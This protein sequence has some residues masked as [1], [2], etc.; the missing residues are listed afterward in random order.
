VERD[1]VVLDGMGHLVQG[2][3]NGTG[4]DLYDRVNVTVK[5]ARISGFYYGVHI[6]SVDLSTLFS[7]NITNNEYGI[8]YERS[9]YNIVAGNIIAN[10][11]KGIQLYL[12]SSHNTVTGNN[13]A[14][15]GFGIYLEESSDNTFSGNNITASHESGIGIAMSLNNS[16]SGNNI[17]NNTSYGISLWHTSSNTVSGNIVANSR[18]GISL[19][20]SSSNIVSE[21]NI[22]ANSIYG[23]GLSD[24]ANNNN[25]SGNDITN[26]YKGIVLDLSLSDN[27]FFHNN[28]A[29]NTLQFDVYSS[30][31]ATVW[32][33]GYPSGGN[34]WSDY[35]G[36][37]ANH[38]GIGDTP[39]IIDADNIDHYPLI[40]EFS[41]FL[42][43]PLFM[44]A[45][46]LAVIVYKRKHTA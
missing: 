11:S 46:L 14:E 22:T 1:N 41:S 39:Y 15:G 23:I 37:D 35:T 21:N 4:I 8:T 25:F 27:R 6:V 7:N 10:Y 40:P 3:G 30:G 38:D 17:T 19:D 43:L 36:T 16:I 26:N 9:S 20:F 45:S 34:Y 28:F 31:N 44:V 32:D 5:K 29:D 13:V 42:I 2:N 33:D 24:S 18:Y 12:N